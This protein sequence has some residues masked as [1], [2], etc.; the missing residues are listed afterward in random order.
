MKVGSLQTAEKL[1]QTPGGEDP[2]VDSFSN[3]SKQ[4]SPLLKKPLTLACI[5][6]LGKGLNGVLISR[7]V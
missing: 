3:A 2:V 6:F 4:W 5:T 1:L 7:T